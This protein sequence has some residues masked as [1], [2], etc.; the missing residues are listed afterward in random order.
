MA[1][2]A[3]RVAF[4]YPLRRPERGLVHR[5]LTEHL[6]TFL[7]RHTR[8][9]DRPGL[10]AFIR[11]ELRRYLA[12]GLFSSGFARVHCPTC[13]R[14]LLVAFS[15][16]GRGFCPSCGG[17]R[18]A[19]IA[20]HLTDHVLPDVPVRQWVVTFPWRIRFLLSRDP[21]LLRAVRSIALRALL[22][23]YRR[24]TGFRGRF[25]A[26]GG[27]V[28]MVQRFG[29]ALNLNIHLHALFLDGVYT[30]GPSGAPTW[31]PAPPLTDEDVACLVRTIRDRVL[32]LLRAR[33][34]LDEDPC[35]DEPPSQLS[36]IAAASIQGT[37][38]LGA[39]G[40][41]AIARLGDPSGARDDTPRRTSP[42]CAEIDGF[43]LHAAVRVR[44]GDRDRLEHLCRYI[45]RPALSTERLSLSSQ[46]NILLRLRRPWSDG[47]THIVLQPLAFLERLAAL[48]PRP[49]AHQLT[50]HGAL[51]PASTLRS[52]IL[53]RPPPRPLRP[54]GFAAT[55]G[56]PRYSWAELMKRVFGHDVSLRPPGSTR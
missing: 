34:L 20:A 2:R 48:I 37:S 40:E 52:R 9:P 11:R 35:S 21:D 24:R 18:M 44:A 3:E 19:E 26:H 7:D 5:V 8:D 6:E 10:P 46:G 16:K 33:R 42:L 51:A 49:R 50:Y 27:A 14:D 47:T 4:G 43:S 39:R 53:P 41:A 45:A 38:A 25:A 30:A 22:T 31:H 13:S 54:K 1:S 29:S 28:C 32:R 36:L 55:A 17:R 12:C 23:S 56:D 15:C